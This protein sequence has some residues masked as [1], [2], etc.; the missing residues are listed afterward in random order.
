MS[1]FKNVFDR[2]FTELTKQE[3]QLYQE[4]DKSKQGSTLW[5]NLWSQINNVLL[6]QYNNKCNWMGETPH[7]LNNAI[8]HEY[9]YIKLYEERFCTSVDHICC[10]A[11]RTRRENIKYKL[12]GESKKFYIWLT[13][14]GGYGPLLHKKTF[15]ALYVEYMVQAV[16][17]TRTRTTPVDMQLW[18]RTTLFSNK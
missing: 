17:T 6:L 8:V 13:G 15:D 9:D 7:T 12:A 10:N 3:K 14:P 4:L 11:T 16:K 1:T 5:Y 18:A 2:E